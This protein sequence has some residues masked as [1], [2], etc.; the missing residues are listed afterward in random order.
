MME[1]YDYF[2]RKARKKHRCEFCEK[3]IMPGERYSYEVGKFEG[4]FFVR[5]LCMPCR[6]MLD[7]YLQ[8][9]NTSVFDWTEVSDYLTRHWCTENCSEYEREECERWP[10]NCDVLRLAFEPN[11]Y[12]VTT[13]D[14]D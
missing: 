5:K 4:E 10:Q 3:D 1:F 7:E 8:A 14:I 9:A 11:N 12:E 13:N 6:N 2:T